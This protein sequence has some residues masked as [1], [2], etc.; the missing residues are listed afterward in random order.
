M[1]YFDLNFCQLNVSLYCHICSLSC[2]LDCHVCAGQVQEVYSDHDGVPR[3]LL[4]RQ[5][6][7]I[8][9]LL[10]LQPQ[11]HSALITPCSVSHS[12]D[13]SSNNGN[14]WWQ[15]LQKASLSS[16]CRLSSYATKALLNL[17]AYRY[18]I[19]DLCLFRICICTPVIMLVHI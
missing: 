7:R 16:V 8:L 4:R 11:S 3:L 14:V 1:G 12:D 17:E 9:A 13:S 2:N 10:A 18:N 5:T 19:L 15:W 6:A